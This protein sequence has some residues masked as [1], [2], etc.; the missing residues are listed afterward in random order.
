MATCVGL[1][2]CLVQLA[3][4]L[5]NFLEECRVLGH[6]AA[7]GTLGLYTRA[8]DLLL[9]LH[10]IRL[11]LRKVTSLLLLLAQLLH[12]VRLIYQTILQRPQR[13]NEA[14]ELDVAITE[15]RC[16]QQLSVAL[17]GTLYFCLCVARHRPPAAQR[18]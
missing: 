13:P 14:P 9:Q 12:R 11:E 10:Y 18:R 16:R 15:A 5:V 6:N 2:H 3:T 4:E 1:Y 7:S 17:A 8:C